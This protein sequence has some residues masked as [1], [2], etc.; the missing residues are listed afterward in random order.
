MTKFLIAGYGSIGRRHFRNLKTLGEE[1]ILFLR[2][3]RSTLPVEE[4]GDYPVE[5]DLEKALAHCPDAVIVANPTAAHLD[6]AIPA[7]AAGCHLLLEKP[8]SHDIGRIAELESALQIGGG[9]VLVGYQFRFH[10]ILQQ[11]KQL[12]QANVL[13]KIFSVRAHWGEYLPGWHPWEDYRNSYS[14]R[15]DLG[16]GVTIT[17]SHPIDYLRWFFGEVEALWAFAGQVS[18]LELDVD[19]F[20]EAG[21]RFACGVQA[22]LHLNYFQRPGVHHF[23]IIGSN[24]TLSWDNQDGG[25]HLY[26]AED[27]ATQD[28]LLPEGFDRNDLFLEEMRHFLEIIAGRAN[29]L[30]DLEDGKSALNVAQA[31]LKSAACGKL[32]TL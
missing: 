12:L 26:L 23:E 29:T 22:S 8:I 27:G 24:G 32:I 9:S 20:A 1:D 11:V 31:I 6:V 18:S 28:L 17:L 13:G 4:L 7:A 19:D 15:A 30:C 3:G 2:S 16:G 25:A 21:I 5:T 10:P 14:A